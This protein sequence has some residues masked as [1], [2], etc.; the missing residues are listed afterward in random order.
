V[1]TDDA[2]VVILSPESVNEIRNDN[3][4]SFTHLIAQVRQSGGS[5]D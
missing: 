3:R 2:R 4:F 1:E 5:P